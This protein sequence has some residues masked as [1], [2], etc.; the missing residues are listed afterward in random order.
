MQEKR[1]I[2]PQKVVLADSHQGMLGGVRSLL[3]TT[4]DM[5]FIV[6]D[7]V[8]LIEVAE[9]IHPDLIIADLSLKAARELNIVRSLKMRFPETKLIILSVHNEQTAI[10]E[11]IEAG[12]DGFVLKRSAVDDLIPA[13]DAINSNSRFIYGSDRKLLN[14]S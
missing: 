14:E 4:F 8:S 10:D 3:E 1:R 6:A 7:E 11:C 5:V 2:Q 12:A 13:I 9:K